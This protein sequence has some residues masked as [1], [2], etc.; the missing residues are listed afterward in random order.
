MVNPQFAVDMLGQRSRSLWH[1]WA[2]PFEEV[3]ISLFH[4]DFCGP[5]QFFCRCLSYMLRDL[6]RSK[7]EYCNL[8]G[9]VFL[10]KLLSL[11]EQFLRTFGV[12][13]FQLQSTET[14]VVGTDSQDFA[15]LPS[16]NHFEA[17]A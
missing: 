13:T 7:R 1:L 17:S 5:S 10:S 9:S 2:P 14:D 12:A 8:N 3:D 6:L 11:L 15:V 16:L 4:V